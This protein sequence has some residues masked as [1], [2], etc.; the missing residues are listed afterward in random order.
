M[1][2]VAV[3]NVKAAWFDPVGYGLLLSRCGVEQSGSSLGS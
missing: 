3:I 2:I 1:P